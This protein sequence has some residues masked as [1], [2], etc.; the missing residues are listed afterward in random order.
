MISNGANKV[1]AL[2][3][4]KLFDEYKPDIVISTHPFGSQMTAFLKSK[5]K[6]N[7]IL[8]SVMTDFASHDQWLVGH[9][10]I[11]Y[12]FVSHDGMK[13][14]IISKSVAKKISLVFCSE[15]N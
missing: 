13:K 6:T 2:K 11:D 10:Y 14:E 3:L 15:K 12:I 1:M 8:A 9:E 4:N 7:C 5:G